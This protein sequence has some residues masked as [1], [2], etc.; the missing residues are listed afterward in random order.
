MQDRPPPLVL[1]EQDNPSDADHAA[2]VVGCPTLSAADVNIERTAPAVRLSGP[3]LRVFAAGVSAKPW[4]NALW[5]V[6]D[7]FGR[8]VSHGEAML[9]VRL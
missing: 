4:A 8:N 5:F 9:S 3:R 6:R 7:R 1:R 2:G